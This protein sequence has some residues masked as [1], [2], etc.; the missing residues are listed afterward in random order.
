MKVAEKP[1]LA[2]CGGQNLRRVGVARE[3]QV[4]LIRQDAE[5][6]ERL[7]LRMGALPVEHPPYVRRVV[8]K[9]AFRL[10]YHTPLPHHVGFAPLHR[11]SLVERVQP[12]KPLLDRAVRGLLVGGLSHPI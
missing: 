9:T 2:Y 12:P 7:N 10:R 11:E 1:W 5:V 4:S 8:P 6:D 3:P